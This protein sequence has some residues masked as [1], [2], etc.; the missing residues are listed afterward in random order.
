VDDALAAGPPA[1]ASLARAARLN[2]EAVQDLRAARY[3]DGI[4]KAR[5]ALALREQALRP[6]HPDIAVSL[7]NLA[8][9]LAGNGE[10]G[11]ARS[12]YE[13]AV[14]IWEQARG[15]EDLEVATTLNNL[16]VLLRLTGQP[17]A[18][19]ALY[20]RVL[21][22][23][24]HALG[25]LHA[26][27][28]QVLSNMSVVAEALADYGAA[29]SLAE[30]ALRIWE[31]ALGPEHPDVAMALNNLAFVLSAA[32]DYEAARAHYGR[33][34]AIWEQALGPEHPTVAQAL[35]NEAL[36][37]RATGRYVEARGLLERALRIW[38]RTVGT[39]HPDYATG[40]HSLGL[41][42]DAV[43]DYGAARGLYEEALR[44][45]E[46][47]LGPSHPTV[48]TTVNS[49]GG[50]LR[51]MGDHASALALYERALEIRR[52]T[53]PPEHPA[54][55]TAMSHLAYL[56]HLTGDSTRALPLAEEA[57]A[58]RE[59]GFGPDH[60]DVM[61][62]LTTTAIILEAGGDT[63]RAMARYERVLQT[64]SS[65]PAPEWRWRAA[66]RLGAIH[67]QAGRLDDALA[68]YRESIRALDLL[69][70]QFADDASRA[71]YVRGND[72]LD[73]YD[74][75]AR[76]LLKL[77]EQD[78]SRGHDREAWA[79]L[80]AKKGRLVAEVL[81]TRGFDPHNLQT[82]ADQERVRE[83]RQ[84]AAAL[85]RAVA[86]ERAKAPAAQEPERVR[87]L[88]DQLA[89]TK[90]EYVAEVKAFLAKYPR[91]KTLF[92][93]Q[94]TVDPEAAAKFAGRL[95][96]G[97]L[98]VQYFAA[99][100][101][102]YLFVVG[103]GGHFQVK[104]QAIAQRDLYALVEQYR[105]HV[106]TA[107]AGVRWTDGGA[108]VRA[109]QAI[110]RDLARHLLDPIAQELATHS[111]LI[112]IPNDLLLYLPLHALPTGSAD[113]PWRFLAETHTVSYVTSQEMVET[114]LT[115]SRPSASHPLLALADPDGSLPSASAE[116][117]ALRG[118]RPEVTALAGNEAT[119][120]RFL[121]LVGRFRDLHLATHGRLDRLRPERSYLLMAGNDEASQRLE[122][123]EIAGLDLQH[124]GLAILSACE[125]AL[126]EQV[127]GAALISLAAA[128]SLG[129]SSSV[130]ASL[131]RIDDA[132]T[133]DF[134]VAFHRALHSGG[135][136]TAVQA[137]QLALLR[138]AA[139]AHPYYWAGFVLIGAR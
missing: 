127:P 129:G 101:A 106:E 46:T 118:I 1:G 50:L 12:L 52:T 91:Y 33:A 41:V 126:G 42:L 39:E 93:D 56:L 124:D 27:V 58:I 119:K 11:A 24:E 47:T 63:T 114:F 115:A 130:L 120:A 26:D 45:G 100:D 113:R 67:E 102:L 48:A 59:R 96:P 92:V 36:L 134:M 83:R 131:W 79:V 5:E 122:V 72:R 51:Q 132:A 4:V 80:E 13:R 37:W 128:F 21:R 38:E 31:Q 110:G 49:L 60:P 89:R 84:Q 121:S 17:A 107:R 77:H 138:N 74:V 87:N 108:D 22:I 104:R 18:A 43:G 62:S 94:K 53:L 135:R 65:H 69:G 25:A 111:A 116:V 86:D 133:R 125:T 16:A 35:S 66:V 20:E 7:N 139:T 29:R 64:T 76:L 28:A 95:P 105:M 30:R 9:L 136:V 78:S 97:T 57:L 88:T 82:Q 123:R 73:A 32:G 2:D 23:R 98:A 8:M 103:P 85:E 117:Q 75:L 81:G 3:R 70:R 61:S 90:A 99:P 6:G 55:A 15:P 68:A 14:R 19:G 40:L 10:Y 137:A 109:L 71:L 112:V 54:I 34:L 44:I